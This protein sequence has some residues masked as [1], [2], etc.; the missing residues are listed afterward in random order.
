MTIDIDQ[1]ID[2]ELAEVRRKYPS[3]GFELDDLA[4]SRLVMAKLAERAGLPEDSPVSIEVRAIPGPAELPA[5]GLRIFTPP[6]AGDRALPALLWIHGGGYVMGSAAD[7]DSRLGELAERVGCVVV[8]VDY[9]LAPEHPY[10]A[11]LDDCAAALA[12]LAANP[13]GLG[14]DSGRIALGGA[15]AGAGLAAA[16]AQRTRDEQGTRPVFQLL[17]YPMLDDR[18][19]QPS[20]HAITDPGLWNRETNLKAWRM[21][22]GEAGQNRKGPS[23]AVPARS[24]HLAA[25]PPAFVAV[26]DLDLFLDENINYA[27]RLLQA[28]VPTELHV[29]TGAI[30]GFDMLAPA[31]SLAVR[32]NADM[33]AAL[34]RALNTPCDT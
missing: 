16:L 20:T 8:A 15:S 32:L 3:L 12:W 17:I 19:E 5:V 14:V 34:Q 7:T 26:G 27:Q 9:R 25:L 11:A 24:E 2:A 1:R 18:N 30:H 23:Y 33:E 4:A 13:E 21:Y 22:L 10:P 6:S 29:Y 31:S 28:G